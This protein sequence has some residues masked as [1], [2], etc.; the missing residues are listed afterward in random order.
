M[1]NKNKH[2][3]FDIQCQKNVS[4]SLHKILFHLVPSNKFRIMHA[5]L[6]HFFELV[7]L[8]NTLSI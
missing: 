4:I 3:V 5:R 6:T 7:K 8:Y 1:K 2:F